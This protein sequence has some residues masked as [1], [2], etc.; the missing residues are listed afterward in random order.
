MPTFVYE[1]LNAAGKTEKGRI[2][3]SSSDEA[4]SAIRQQGFFPTS[5]REDSVGGSGGKKGKK[6]KGEG[7]KKK[8]ITISFGKVK[9]K[10][11]CQFT[12]QLST[13][14]DAGLPLP[15]SLQIL[16]Q[17]QNPGKVKSILL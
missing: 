3:A 5:V 8:G 6:V 2:D 16:D 9:T 12:R 13:L 11:L 14:Q 1:A 7:K 15:R 10:N 4:I 17:Q